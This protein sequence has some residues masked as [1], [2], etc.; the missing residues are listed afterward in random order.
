VSEFWHIVTDPAHA[1]A[2][3]AW[4]I[5]E[6]VLFGLLLWPWIK[7]MVSA[8]VNAEHREID[9][10]HGVRHPNA[11]MRFPGEAFCA[12]CPDHEGCSQGMPCGIV[13][14]VNLGAPKRIVHLWDETQRLDEGNRR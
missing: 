3:A 5:V 8:R 9:I 10:E 6:N 1:G 7:R 13:R 14:V 11:D 12:D 2:E 4:S